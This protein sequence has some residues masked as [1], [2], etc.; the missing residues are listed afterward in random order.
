MKGKG[1]T[2][3]RFFWCVNSD[4]RKVPPITKRTVKETYR[5]HHVEELHY[6]SQTDELLGRVWT[7][8]FRNT[9]LSMAN[10]CQ[11]MTKTTTIL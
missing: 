9:C 8:L 11:C 3:K 1:E 10:S 2:T 7:V 5:N 4:F 6:G